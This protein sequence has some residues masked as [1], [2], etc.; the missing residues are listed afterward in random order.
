MSHAY[1]GGKEGQKKYNKMM[2]K[3]EE[4]KEHGASKSKALHKAKE[5][6]MELG[7]Y[8]YHKKGTASGGGFRNGK[9]EHTNA[10]NPHK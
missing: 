9:F 6:K 3:G 4:K 8:G 10:S 5:E 7:A 2:G 1:F